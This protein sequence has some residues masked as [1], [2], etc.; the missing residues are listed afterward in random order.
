MAFGLQ[1]GR[2]TPYVVPKGFKGTGVEAAMSSEGLGPELS[3]HP[4]HHILL[5]KTSGRSTLDLRA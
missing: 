2:Q 1:R 3:E 5:F 4:F